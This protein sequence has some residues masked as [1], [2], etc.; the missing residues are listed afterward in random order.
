MILRISY[1]R[2][3]FALIPL[4]LFL[5][6]FPQNIFVA[7]TI[8]LIILGMVFQFSF[9]IL[10]N[11]ALIFFIIAPIVHIY[12]DVEMAENIVNFSFFFMITGVVGELFFSSTKETPSNDHISRKVSSKSSAAK[13]KMTRK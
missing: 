12:G 6:L 8:G 13:A 11:F 4:G 7:I 2:S 9:H 5:L 1:L 3:L 10:F